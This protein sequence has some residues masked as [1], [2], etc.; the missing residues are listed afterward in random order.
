MPGEPAGVKGR[1]RC[2]CGHDKASHYEHTAVVETDD[3]RTET[4]PVRMACLATYCECPW[5]EEKEAQK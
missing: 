1:E 5:F 2:A 3:G 4:K